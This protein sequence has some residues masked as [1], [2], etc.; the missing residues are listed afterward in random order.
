V[1]QLSNKNVSET[2]YNGTVEYIERDNDNYLIKTEEYNVT[3]IIYNKYIIS[4]EVFSR[5][6][7]GDKITFRTMKME[8]H[9]YEYEFV[10]LEAITLNING[11]DVITSESRVE[12]DRKKNDKEY[13][14]VLPLLIV[15]AICTMV[16][17]VVSFIK[18]KKEKTLK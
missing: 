11:V 15:S 3:L 2:A 16:Y 18:M 12:V 13:Q 5:I 1:S 7:S 8:K 9:F 14:K 6:S 17:S 4:E 10:V